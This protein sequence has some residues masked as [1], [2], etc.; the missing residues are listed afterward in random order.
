MR[1]VAFKWYYVLFFFLNSSHL[2]AADNAVIL[3]YHHVS[4]KTPAAT[5]VTPDTFRQ[6]MQYMVENHDV[7]PLS[8]IVSRL[9]IGL[10]L[11]SRA[12]AITFDDGY[13]NIFHNAHPILKSFNFPYT[14]FINPSLIGRESYQLTWSQVRSMGEEGASFANHANVHQHLL[15]RL[16]KESQ[17]QWLERI[18]A[19]IKTAELTL[20]KQLGYSLRYL[21]YPYGEYNAAL[22]KRIEKHEY[23]GFAQHSGAIASH[24]DFSALPRFPAAGIYSNL[25]SL[26][27]KLNS[28]AM[29]VSNVSPQDPSIEHG[30]LVN[31]AFSV[32]V[33]DIKP[34]QLACFYLGA[35][36]PVTRSSNRFTVDI[37]FSTPPG[38]SRVNCTAPSLRQGGRFYWYSQPWFMPDIDGYWLE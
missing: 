25:S 24:S 20:K 17:E 33:E 27:V 36:L 2:W 1:I 34:A 23:V 14:V 38:R 37:P 21:A 10:P 8:T 18:M 4:D 11:P 7:L 35:A 13:H 3:M 22:K 16:P 12:V 31:M 32:S 6:H 5:S 15:A 30:A 28:L 19:D 9:K 29:P 26:K